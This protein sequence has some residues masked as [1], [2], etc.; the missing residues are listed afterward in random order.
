LLGFFVYKEY[1]AKK[2]ANAELENKNRKV[3]QAYKIIEQNRDEIALKNKDISDSILYAQRIQ[4]AML[5]SREEIYKALPEHFIFYRPKDVVSGDF[6]AFAEKNGQTLLAAVDCTGH[7]VPGAFMSMIGNDILN[8]VII[9]KGIT[10]PS[11]VLAALNRSVKSSLKQ[12][13]TAS[14]AADG[15]DI[16]L[17]SINRDTLQLQYSGAHRPLYVI[18]D[19]SGLKVYE[20]DNASIGGYTAKEH[21]FTNHSITLNKGDVFYIFTD[22][23]TDQFGGEKGKKYMTKRLK[24][25]MLEI[26]KFP[27]EKQYSIIQKTFDDWKK[28]HEQVDDVLII[29]VRI[30]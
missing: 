25:L 19:L 15:M 22:G 10:T 17:C 28:G 30:S 12:T 7:G 14:E 13:G 16:A 9:E 20:A 4:Q 21:S 1:R 8:Q 26:Y 11:E 27:M 3:E 2:L 29:G 6:Y 24:D 18:S 23:F 5:P